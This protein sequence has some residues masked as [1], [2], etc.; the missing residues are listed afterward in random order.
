MSANLRAQQSFADRFASVLRTFE[1]EGG[2]IH[3]LADCVSEEVRDLRRWADG[4]KMPAHVLLALIGELPR[5]LAD[6]LIR[7]SG[8]RLIAQDIAADANALLASS[9]A[10]AFASGITARHADGVYCHRDKEETRQEA[11]RLIADLQSLAGE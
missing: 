10:S 7:P 2:D 3:R 11:R 1:R 9:K 5:H 8:L 4:T 6:M